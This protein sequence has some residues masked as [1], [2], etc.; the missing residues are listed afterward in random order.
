MP[1]AVL[2]ARMVRRLRRR[3]S[4]GFGLV[5]MAVLVSLLGNAA[6]FWAFDGRDSGL[7]F[8]DAL[9][10]SIISI[11]TIGYGDYSASSLGAR[12]GTL[13]F[14]I[15]IGLS[16]FTVFLGMVVD[17]GMELALRGRYGMG[18]VM[19]S[20][21]VIIVNFPS[22]LRVRRMIEELQSDVITGN[23][24]V[25]VVADTI[26]RLPF[27]IPNVLFIRGSPIEVETLQRARVEAASMA[28]VLTPSED[29]ATGDAVVSAAVSVLDD[30]R[31]ELQIV[32]ECLDER[33]ERLFRSVNCDGIV[34]GQVITDHLL[35]QEV[36]DPGVS[37]MIDII[38]SNVRG[39]TLYSA[40]VTTAAESSWNTF[41][42]A[43]LDADVNVLCVNCGESSY[44]RFSDVSPEPGDQVIFLSQTRHA[45]PQLLKLAGIG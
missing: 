22:A 21:H 30:L 2:I 28:I 34:Y 29:D 40:Q 18:K 26:E 35:V 10:Y 13:V 16:A 33:H 23:R 24:E 15:G 9:W 11:T 38:T 3:K 1:V 12:L 20:G 14:I 44:T 27:D 19:A 6:C 4:L 42:K 37:Q 7:S 41:A 8:V 45:W 39:D 31:P 36:A 25:V 43:L 17:W 5:L 32:A